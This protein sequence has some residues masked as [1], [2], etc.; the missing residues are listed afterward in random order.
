MPFN[1]HAETSFTEI[2]GLDVD[3]LASHIYPCFNEMCELNLLHGVDKCEICSCI[4]TCI[5]LLQ[6]WVLVDFIFTND[7]MLVQYMLSSC[8]CPSVCPSVTSRQCTRM[9]KHRIMQT[10]PYNSI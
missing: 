2:C 1:F 4:V 7:A 10:M 3:I 8:F 6:T 9:A 5:V